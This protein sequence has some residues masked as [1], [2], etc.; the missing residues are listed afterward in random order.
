M[1]FSWPNLFVAG[2]VAVLAWLMVRRRGP[3]WLAPYAEGPLQA[4]LL[5]ALYAVWQVV[6]GFDVFRVTG[7]FAHARAVW[8]IER[9][10]HVPS[11]ASLQ[12]L[13]LHHRGLVEAGNV[14]YETF[15]YPAMI[16][17]LAW[18]FLR[19]RDRYRWARATLVLATGASAFIQAVPVAPPRLVDGLRV[20][21]TAR[22]YGQSVY[23]ATGGRDPGQTTAMPSV[24]VLWAVL[25]GLIVVTSTRSRWRW[26]ALAH[27]VLTMLAVVATGNHFWLDGVAGAALVALGSVTA[28]AV[29]G[30]AR[31][32]AGRRSERG[33]PPATDVSLPRA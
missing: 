5:V 16:A 27:P 19:H 26:L 15:H 30:S 9:A 1:V 10:W 8:R 4:A 28:T 31:P 17:A 25:V 7:A 3:R 33:R 2:E 21:D 20:V 22:L 11:E 29:V 23:A 12:H 6:L 32:D 18:L 24:H 13:V 14:F